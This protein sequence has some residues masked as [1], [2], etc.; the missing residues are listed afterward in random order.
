MKN[1]LSP[2]MPTGTNEW[3]GLTKRE[4]VAIEAMTALINVYSAK[5]EGHHK[6]PAQ[7]KVLTYAYADKMFNHEPPL[8]E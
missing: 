1:S 7:I 4:Y 8:A 2:S 3:H 6:D 5:G